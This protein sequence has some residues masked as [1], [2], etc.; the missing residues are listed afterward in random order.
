M[1][2]ALAQ[3]GCSRSSRDVPLVT[4][5]ASYPGANAQVVA[6]TV[7]VP[8]EQ[9]VNGVEDMLYMVSQSNNDGSCT[10]TVTFKPGVNLE[11]AQVLVQ[12][13]V[14]LAMPILPDAVK[15]TGVAVKRGVAQEDD[16]KPV[17]IALLDRGD[18]GWKALRGWSEAV[19][20]RLTA[21]GVLVKPEVFPGPDEKQI[22]LLIDRAKCVRIGVAEA[23][24]HKAVQKAG[25]TVKMEALKQRTV[26]SAR[27][28]EVPLGAVAAFLEVTAPVAVFR[29]NMYPAVRISGSPAEG[30]TRVKA[31][32][33]CLEL[34]E[35]QRKEVSRPDGFMAV[36]LTAR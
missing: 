27:G 26:T 3:V 1:A 23:D 30:K 31:A 29:V 17:V 32:R 13:R 22:R 24:V 10:L 15:Q 11:V 2:F 12:N 9:Q 4:V 5:T 19:V 25:P 18:H 7:A 6:E 8:I 34:A 36:N 14:S 28:D 33:M 16:T 20:E 35:A 21:D